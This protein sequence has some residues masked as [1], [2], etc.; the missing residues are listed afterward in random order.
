M[1]RFEFK[2]GTVVE[3]SEDVVVIL[4]ESAKSALKTLALGRASGKMF[5]K[6]SSISSVIFNTD[7]L[8]IT[9]S[10]LPCPNEF[11]ISKI[12]DVKEYPNCIVAKQDELQELYDYLLE[13]ISKNI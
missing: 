8:L 4:R 12:G 5:I 3:I 10:G 7:F 2:S 9:G 13:V 6:T 1:K 11:K